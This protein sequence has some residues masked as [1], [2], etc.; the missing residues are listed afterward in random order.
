MQNTTDYHNYWPFFMLYPSAVPPSL[1]PSNSPYFNNSLFFWLSFS[2][3]PSFIP[4]LFISQQLSAPLLSPIMT[5]Y[6]AAVSD[7]WPVRSNDERKVKV[8]V[9]FRVH[10]PAL[11]HNDKDSRLNCIGTETDKG[12]EG[13][14]QTVGQRYKQM[15]Q[16]TQPSRVNFTHT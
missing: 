3:C 12:K 9:W 2:I 6:H 16:Q 13:D 1:P 4:S 10:R 8:R 11:Q 14:T 7:L 5:A 15:E